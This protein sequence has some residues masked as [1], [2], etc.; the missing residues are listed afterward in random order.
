MVLNSAAAEE[1]KL[2]ELARVEVAD[3]GLSEFARR[4]QIDA[5]NLNKIVE[6]KRKLSRQLAVKF[7]RYFRASQASYAEILG[8]YN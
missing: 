1:K 4:L 3:I 8:R 2:L 7:E 5:A 6:G